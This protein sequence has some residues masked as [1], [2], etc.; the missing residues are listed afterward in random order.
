M[1]HSGKA[2]A[3]LCTGVKLQSFTLIE[4]L[5]VIAIIAILAGMLL[6][7][8]NSAREKGRASSCVNNL[9]QIGHYT[10]IYAGDNQ[11]HFPELNNSI[12]TWPRVLQKTV[13]YGTS[14]TA[15]QMNAD[16]EKQN[17]LFYCPNVKPKEKTIGGVTLKGSCWNPGY[18]A[19]TIGPLAKT[20]KAGYT[21]SNWK[22]GRTSNPSSSILYADSNDGD[23]S[24]V[25]TPNGHYYINVA[26]GKQ[27]FGIRHTGKT[28]VAHVDGSVTNY[29]GL[30]L[31]SRLGGLKDKVPLNS[32]C[33]DD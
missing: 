27:W 5:V 8:L 22:M 3:H 31:V 6:P 9:K 15:D 32:D 14:A 19:F 28:N 12:G 7:A 26:S 1:K 20:S 25:Q 21:T 13:I 2:T 29:D 4:L 23:A 24:S 11:E 30:Y 18:G 10:F 16:F 33:I 17:C